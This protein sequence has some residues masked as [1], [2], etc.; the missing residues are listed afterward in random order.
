MNFG[1]S[2][3][4][5]RESRVR[6]VA[7][8]CSG[9]ARTTGRPTTAVVRTRRP[10]NE[11]L[12]EPRDRAAAALHC[13]IRLHAGLCIPVYQEKNEEIIGLLFASFLL[14]TSL[15]D[16]CAIEAGEVAQKSA[17]D[18]RVA[19]ACGRDVEISRRAHKLSRN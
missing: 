1:E 2:T 16:L 3:E 13:G 11:V 8:H 12:G 17:R 19:P 6:L 7:P 4:T 9:V 18:Q 10:G 15:L 5:K 14:T